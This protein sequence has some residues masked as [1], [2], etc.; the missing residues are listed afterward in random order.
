MKFG[1]RTSYNKGDRVWVRHWV[2]V[3]VATIV[4]L[5]P[6]RRDAAGVLLRG[7]SYTVQFDTDEQPLGKE[8]YAQSLKPATEL[9]SQRSKDAA[10]DAHIKALRGREEKP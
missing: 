9:E 2:V 7:I 8:F 10:V 5:H 4:A 1:Q 3:G 6:L